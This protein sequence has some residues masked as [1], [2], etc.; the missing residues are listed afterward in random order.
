MSD[1]EHW[2]LECS[3]R[4]SE[5][6]LTITYACPDPQKSDPAHSPGASPAEPDYRAMWEALRAWAREAEEASY[7]PGRIH[8]SSELGR[9]QAYRRLLAE[10]EE[11]E[12]RT[13]TPDPTHAPAVRRV[14]AWVPDGGPATES[15]D[16]AYATAALSRMTVIGSRAPSTRRLHDRMHAMMGAMGDGMAAEAWEYWATVRDR[17]AA[18]LRRRDEEAGH[19]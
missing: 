7:G 14:V 1:Q 16:A 10:M 4:F 2:C 11:V 5:N 9:W 19:R 15:R 6:G 18:Y 8:A 13:C 3:E 17:L 12:G